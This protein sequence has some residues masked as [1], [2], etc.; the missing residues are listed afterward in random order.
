MWLDRA[1]PV[2][3]WLRVLIGGNSSAEKIVS[4]I[5]SSECI[6]KPSTIHH[7]S[8]FAAALTSI[9]FLPSVI[10]V[11]VV[12]NA[13][14][15]IFLPQELLLGTYKH[16]ILLFVVDSMRI[17]KIILFFFYKWNYFFHYYAIKIFYF[18]IQCYKQ[19]IIFI[20][21][22]CNSVEFLIFS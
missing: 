8:K 3:C 13:Q 22:N 18:R 16:S 15:P 19:V 14:L 17:A 4:Y 6:N 11:H 21:W 2:W 20:Y 12:I 1:L 10:P 7:Y 5:N 9:I